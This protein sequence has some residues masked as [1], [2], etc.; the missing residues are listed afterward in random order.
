MARELKFWF[1]GKVYSLLFAHTPWQFKVAMPCEAVND[2]L[3]PVAMMRAGMS[4][5]NIPR[6]GIV[7][8]YT[9]SAR[10]QQ[11]SNVQVPPRCVRPRIINGQQNRY[12]CVYSI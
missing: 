7:E 11:S 2:R 10:F 12:K 6:E 9:V 8:R 4:N 1:Y 3:V 5:T